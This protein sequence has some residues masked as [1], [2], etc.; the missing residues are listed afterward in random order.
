MTELELRVAATSATFARFNG[1][2]L[3]LGSMDCARM[4]A[5]HLK[6]IGFK[7]SLLKAGAYSTPVGARRALTRMGVTSLSEIMDRH[8]PRWDSP[9]E[10]RVGDICCVAGDGDM[11]DAMQVKLHRNHVLGFHDG[12]CGELV[13]QINGVAWRVI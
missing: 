5:F 12:V 13:N 2:S 4:T 9:S 1:Q 11:G 10:A 8:F 7:P 3:V 6:Q